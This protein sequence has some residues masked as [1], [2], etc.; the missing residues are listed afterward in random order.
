VGAVGSPT[1]WDASGAGSDAARPPAGLAAGAATD[2]VPLDVEGLA[3]ALALPLELL[4]Q[5]ATDK[6]MTAQ[7]NAP[8]AARGLTIFMR[9]SLWVSGSGAAHRRHQ[10]Q[11]QRLA[12]ASIDTRH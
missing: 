7:L 11:V 8:A 12:P 2:G 9:L 10:I 5:A 3:E 4:P 6:A 1:Y